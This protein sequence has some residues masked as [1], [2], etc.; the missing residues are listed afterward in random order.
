MLDTSP[1][2]HGPRRGKLH[3]HLQTAL[4]DDACKLS[5]RRRTVSAALQTLQA[6]AVMAQLAADI[7]GSP[8]GVS[9]R[10]CKRRIGFGI[11]RAST[12]A[13]THNQSRAVARPEPRRLT[14]QLVG[15][16]WLADPWKFFRCPVR[17]FLSGRKRATAWFPC[18][19]N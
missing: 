6:D 3:R 12:H 4:A 19:R 11:G 7:A 15:G 1:P 17:P 13:S 5:G 9:Q 18:A 10:P 2:S 8:I 16:A 14:S